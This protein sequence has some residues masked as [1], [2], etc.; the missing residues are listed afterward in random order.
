[1]ELLLIIIIAIL[2]VG[3]GALLSAVAGIFGMAIAIVAFIAICFWF[4]FHPG[5][6][7]VVFLVTI[8]AGM[9]C[10]RLYQWEVLR[11]FQSH[12]ESKGARN[13]AELVN[14]IRR[15]K[16]LSDEQ[17]A[18]AISGFASMKVRKS[19]PEK[20]PA[21]WLHQEQLDRRLRSSSK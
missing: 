20:S 2:V 19:I 10:F 9:A 16:S 17:L 21:D 5:I 6:A 3:S 7:M 11:R 4:G 1:M 8:L 15:R 18:G 12:L 14:N 13:A